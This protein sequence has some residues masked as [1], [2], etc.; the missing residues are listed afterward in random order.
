MMAMLT[1][2]SS[3][4][5]WGRA[6]PAALLLGGVLL[7]TAAGSGRAHAAP[8]EYEL[9]IF[10]GAHL[11]NPDQGFG[12]LGPQSKLDHTAAFGLRLGLGLHPRFALEAE[13][14]LSPTTT[15]PLTDGANTAKVMGVGYRLHGL[16]HFATGR[17]RPYL[18][19]GGGGLSTTTSDSLIVLAHNG[20]T[21]DGGLGLKVDVK[22]NWGLRLEG[23][24][25]LS[26]GNPDA[27]AIVPNGE[28]TLGLYGRFGAPTP[29]PKPALPPEGDADNDG[30]TNAVDACPEQAGVAASKGCPVAPGDADGDGFPDATDKC[31][32]QAEVKNDWADDDG[33]PDEAP[34]P[35]LRGVVG[36]LSGVSFASDK[37]D[38]L[39]ES[40]PALDRV[41]Q[42]LL[43]TPLAK[44][45]I[46]GYTDNSGTTEVN[47]E[48]SQKRA[49]AVK[50]Y[51][52]SKGV[53]PA[54]LMAKG[55]G[56]E[57]PVADNSTPEGREKNR[58][59]ELHLLP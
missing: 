50:A 18:T 56:E 48:L 15:M 12:Y 46:A 11:W 25:L 19:I 49:D 26:P 41:L 37:A 20:Y 38:L 52:I 8:R 7:T 51:L 16:V 31:P 3:G 47:H 24:A 9:G 27:A 4:C 17:V 28:V 23:K 58:R 22:P 6:A 39:P 2:R 1:T 30:V 57:K 59:V 43:V 45:E 32:L 10:V 40:Y 54:R 13:L 14:A 36:P 35:A 53:D 42:A 29:P 33:C 55:Y 44:L 34:P 21:I 5:S